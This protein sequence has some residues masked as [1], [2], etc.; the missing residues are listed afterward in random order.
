MNVDMMLATAAA[1][2]LEPDAFSLSTWL[3][4]SD[5]TICGTVGCVAGT[6]AMICENTR[7]EA[8]HCMAYDQAV[9]AGRFTESGD[10]EV[11]WER[12]DPKTWL[13]LGMKALDLS[14]KEARRLFTSE[15]FWFRAV[16]TLD[17]LADEQITG[18]VNYGSM[19]LESV[20]AKQAAEVIRAVAHG[21]IRISEPL[22]SLPPVG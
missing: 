12:D 16:V 14:A 21:E 13:S 3:E 22:L 18:P 9:R 10:F 4:P 17:L 19:P 1:I 15:A 8:L 6:A 20:T 7:A 5:T 11:D 2:E